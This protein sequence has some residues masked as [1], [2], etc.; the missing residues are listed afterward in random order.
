MW[1]WKIASQA[2]TVT[3]TKAP[4]PTCPSKL[5]L[6]AVPGN[7][8]GGA[9]TTDPMDGPYVHN[10]DVILTANPNPG[11]AFLGW[12]GRPS[13]VDSTPSLTVTMDQDRS[14]TAHFAS[15]TNT[16]APL[17]D[18]RLLT[19]TTPTG[20][21]GG[22]VKGV[23][24]G[25]LGL[26]TTPGNPG[27]YASGEQVALTATPKSGYIFAGW[28][29]SNCDDAQATCTIT[30]NEH[31]TVTASFAP[32]TTLTT[33]TRIEDASRAGGGGSITPASGDHVYPQG[34]AVNLIARAAPT[35]IF[36]RWKVVGGAGA[37]DRGSVDTGQGRVSATCTVTL[38]ADTTVTAYFWGPKGLTVTA[39]A[40]GDITCKVGEGTAANCEGATTNYDHG[41]TV[42]LMAT[43]DNTDTHEFSHWTVSTS[44]GVSGSADTRHTKNPLDVTLDADT[45]VTAV[46][47]AKA[48]PTPTPT[49]EPTPQCTLTVRAGIGG[50]VKVGATTTA[51]SSA[52]WTGDCGTKLSGTTGA[53]AAP[54]ATANSGYS[55]TG[56]SSSPFSWTGGCSG[57][58][59]C[60][61][62]V[63]SATGTAGTYTLTASFASRVVVPPP[64]PDPPP[65][66]PDPPPPPTGGTHSTSSST[67]TRWGWTANCRR[68]GGSGNDNGTK[69]ALQSTAAAVAR[70]WI[71]RNCP[72]AGGTYEIIDTRTYYWSATCRIGAGSHRRSGYTSWSAAVAAG[73]A[74]ISADCPKGGGTSS[75][76]S[77]TQ[78]Y[79]DVICVHGDDFTVGPY[80]TETEARTIGEFTARTLCPQASVS[81]DAPTPTAQASDDDVGGEE[82][83][84]A[85]SVR[86]ATAYGWTA[87]CTNGGGR[88]SGSGHETRSAAASAGRAW[89]AANC[90]GGGRLTTGSNTTHGWEGSCHAGG[91][92]GSGSGHET[93]SAAGIEAGAWINANCAGGGT[94]D[95]P[96]TSTTTWS[97]SASCN[98][99]SRNS[100]GSGL[101]SQAAATS[102]AQAWITANCGG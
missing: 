96:S 46:F 56:W 19:Q 99:G 58:G 34:K 69:Y 85:Y 87:R 80:D 62:T 77:T 68:G 15:R 55:F 16:F 30:M 66:D 41:T 65:P 73:R 64:D 75:T 81:G 59:T 28:S 32:P 89:V 6:D 102:A 5:I 76:N 97:W 33:G 1:L 14:L 101:A 54:R 29:G 4:S 88:G 94:F 67:V 84:S 78:W 60:T 7:G 98:S 47:T 45:T 43:P 71:N 22:E 83:H 49:P 10:E 12:S 13:G 93:R 79:A 2:P 86:S 21:T 74:W 100:S 72:R 3:A 40:S 37:C 48:T 57:T 53:N 24:Q 91:G 44:G 39:S 95:T 82:G 42:T 90:E 35:H 51:A 8:S 17:Y 63:G 20:Q 52:S 11:Y 61:P 36:S 92:T 38:T 50:K 31:R 25:T 26:L 18:L 23:G 70:V 27:T 9:V